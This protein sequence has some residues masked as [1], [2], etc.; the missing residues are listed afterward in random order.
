MEFCCHWSK[1]LL[2]SDYQ[3]GNKKIRI[4]PDLMYKKD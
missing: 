2:V 1:L 3:K 4:S